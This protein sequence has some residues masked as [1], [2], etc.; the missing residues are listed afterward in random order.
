MKKWHLFKWPRYTRMYTFISVLF[1]IF[2]FFRWYRSSAHCF[3]WA[4]FDAMKYHIK[5]KTNKYK[6]TKYFILSSSD[7]SGDKLSF[8]FISVDFFFILFS[9]GLQ[10][11]KKKFISISK[12]FMNFNFIDIEQYKWRCIV[13]TACV[14]CMYLYM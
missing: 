3:L 13:Y 8:W 12:I 5:I 10:S 14:Y 1:Y 7:S 11:H 2:L 4:I 6:W 9:F